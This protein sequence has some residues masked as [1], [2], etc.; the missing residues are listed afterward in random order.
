MVHLIHFYILDFKGAVMDNKKKNFI[1]CTIAAVFFI[2]GFILFL[3]TPDKEYSLSER[4]KLHKKPE[5]S[6]DAVIKGKYMISFEKYS[7]DQFPF[8]EKLREIKTLAVTDIFQMKDKNKLYKYK[9]YIVSMDYPLNKES[10]LYATDRFKY[11]NDTYLNENNN[12]YMSI[13]PD[14]NIFLGE[15][16]GHPFI[17]FSKMESIVK[18]N[19]PYASYISIAHLLSEDDFYKTDTHFKQEKVSD[20]AKE[21]TE[22]METSI[23]TDYKVVDTNQDFYGVYYGQYKGKVSPDNILYLTNDTIENM[24]VFDVENNKEIP[25]YNMELLEDKDPYEMFLSGPLSLVTITNSKSEKDNRLII[26]RDSFGSS[27]APIIATGYKETVLVDIRYVSPK[28]LGRFVDFNNA[29]ILF[30]YSSIVLNN[31]GTIK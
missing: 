29:D 8:R 16:S 4:R 1:V 6:F 28:I 30:L 3:I 12:I 18:E 21:L 24:S 14:K 11:I 26:F 31:S 2:G 27:I 13:I 19:M 25:V 9:D 10:I 5:V 20:V 15:I 7:M 22:A 17:D 23:D